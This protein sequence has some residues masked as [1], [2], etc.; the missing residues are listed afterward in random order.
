MFDE[1]EV[2]HG[3]RSE[4]AVELARNTEQATA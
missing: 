4:V 1:G 3:P 2:L